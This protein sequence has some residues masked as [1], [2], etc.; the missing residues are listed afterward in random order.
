MGPVKTLGL[1]IKISATPG[2]VAAG[3][4][5]YGQRSRVVLAVHGFSN[6]EIAVLIG[7]GAVVA[8]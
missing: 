5:V 1:P 3:A 7:E 4:P 8:T 2:E 6:A